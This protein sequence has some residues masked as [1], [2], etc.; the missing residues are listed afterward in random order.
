MAPQTR[1][2]NPS[3]MNE[4]RQ[5]SQNISA[6]IK[7]GVSALPSRAEAWVIPCAKPRLTAG[8]QYCIARVAVGK[9]A[10]SPKPSATR[11]MNSVSR[12]FTKPVMM[13]AAA[14]IML[15]VSP[16]LS[17]LDHLQVPRGIQRRA[18]F[19]RRHRGVDAAGPVRHARGGKTHL[20]PGQG[21]HQGKFVALA[22]VADAKHLAR[23]FSQA[24]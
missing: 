12:L 14:Q 9:V 6:A 17:G 18:L 3:T 21:S 19:Q 7:G 24:G 5:V 8:V 11:A 2:T 15:I 16:A 10:P 22:E 1:V 20:H 23:E 13:V 4:P